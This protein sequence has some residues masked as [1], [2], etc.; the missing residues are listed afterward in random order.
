MMNVKQVSQLVG[1]S[2]RTLHHYDEIGL[3][4]PDHTTETGYRQY[5]EDNLQTLQHILFFKELG[6]SLKEIR[7]ILQSPDFNTFEALHLQLR[8]LRAKRAQLETMITTIERTIAHVKGEIDMSSEE[9]FA[10]LQWDIN[11]YEQEA[12]ERWGDQAVN[13]SKQRVSK[14]SHGQKEEV[15]KQWDEI[16]SGLAARIGTPVESEETLELTK[17]WFDLL[18]SNFGTYSYDAFI[19][20]GQMYVQDERFTANIDK[21][22]KGLTQYMCDAMGYWGNLQKQ[23]QNQ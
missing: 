9:K 23:K 7:S 8:S 6:F 5:S 1:V 11:P 4:V 13:D 2:V 22:G 21:Y 15:Q 16:Y 12:R 19:G 20:L 18:N 14:L 3:L 17:R 10:G